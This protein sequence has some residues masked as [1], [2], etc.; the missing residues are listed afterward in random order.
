MDQV[1]EA[2]LSS[3]IHWLKVNTHNS[4]DQNKS[5][6]TTQQ[7]NTLATL[8]RAIFIQE[9]YMNEEMKCNPHLPHQMRSHISIIGQVSEI[10][11]Q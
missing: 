7:K 3:E 5:P 9:N 6:Q 4:T 11:S 2:L 1:S 8:M 10:K